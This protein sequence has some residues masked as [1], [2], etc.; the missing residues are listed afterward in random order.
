MMFKIRF[1][2]I[3]VNIDHDH[4]EIITDLKKISDIALLPVMN[5]SSVNADQYKYW[6]PTQEANASGGFDKCEMT[7]VVYP[8]VTRSLA[9]CHSRAQGVCFSDRIP[10]F[11]ILKYNLW[12]FFLKITKKSFILMELQGISFSHNFES[13]TSLYQGVRGVTYSQLDNIFFFPKSEWSY[14]GIKFNFSF[15]LCGSKVC[16]DHL[17]W[18]EDHLWCDGKEHCMD[19]SDEKN[20]DLLC[21]ETLT[22][23]TKILPLGQT[24]VTLSLEI[25]S[26]P[27][28]NEKEQKFRAEYNLN[29]KWNDSRLL[30][31]NVENAKE[32][33]LKEQEIAKVWTPIV[34]MKNTAELEKI[35][36]DPDSLVSVNSD[37]DFNEGNTCLGN[38][39]RGTLQYERSYQTDF[40]C[41]FQLTLF[42]FD[43]QSCLMKFTIRKD[44]TRGA[45]LV[46]G[47]FNYTGIID[48]SQEFIKNQFFIVH[49]E[50]LDGGNGYES[51]V[52]VHF[53]LQRA[54]S[55]I[56]VTKFLPTILL[57]TIGH[58]MN[59]LD[60][61]Y[62]ETILTVNL[63]VMLVLAT[64]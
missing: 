23:D 26:I 48:L 20:C 57:N 31:C 35:L 60:R 2:I 16:N 46:A 59:Y 49:H 25:S 63:T 34:K 9:E 53:V 64:M 42:P 19:G 56:F 8:N 24:N 50:M 30:F 38:K 43:T 4:M 51:F 36:F 47:N 17:S 1:Y 41:K 45:E 58:A 21:A 52:E 55:N 6:I 29:L 61:E 13:K 37:F 10:T 22:E 15:Q 32:T 40:I 33:A 3:L 18:I 44:E 14:Q 5:D 62:F 54:L 39:F 11:Q 7:T 27:D 12:Y 28:I